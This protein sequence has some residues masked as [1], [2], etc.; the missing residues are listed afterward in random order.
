M[1][2]VTLQVLQS[3]L[4]TCLLVELY[5]TKCSVQLQRL[6]L[7]CFILNMKDRLMG[8]MLVLQ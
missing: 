7:D 4:W 3:E 8:N 1:V 5:L 2:D 6:Y